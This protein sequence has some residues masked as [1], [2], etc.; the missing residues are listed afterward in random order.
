ML[1]SAKAGYSIRKACQ[2]V[3]SVRVCQCVL[4][5]VREC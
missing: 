3:P 5:C 1:G 4:T 2:C